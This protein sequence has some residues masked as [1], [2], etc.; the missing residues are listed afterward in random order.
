MLLSLRLS[1]ISNNAC[2]GKPLD[3]LRI[4]SALRFTRLFEMLR[5]SI[6]RG[7]APCGLSCRSSLF[8][9]LTRRLLRLVL[10]RRSP[11]PQTPCHLRWLGRRCTPPDPLLCALRLLGADPIT[12]VRYASSYRW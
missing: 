5:T 9:C 7:P 8:V 6:A 11:L 10:G 12:E 4:S 1:R 2:H 3:P